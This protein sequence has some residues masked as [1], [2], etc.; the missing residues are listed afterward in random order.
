MMNS[1]LATNNVHGAKGVYYEKSG[2]R[3]RPWYVQ[4]M[5]HGKY[6]RYGYFKTKEEATSVAIKQRELLV[7]I[8]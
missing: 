2:N 6:K 8:P 1:K 4:F 3:T 7:A 5:V